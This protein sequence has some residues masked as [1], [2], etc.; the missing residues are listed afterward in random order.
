ME[1]IDGDVRV[2][3]AWSTVL[4]EQHSKIGVC[5]K[6]SRN[7]FDPH[8]QVHKMYLSMFALLHYHGV[9]GSFLLVIPRLMLGSAFPMA[10][11]NSHNVA[12]GPVQMTKRSSINHL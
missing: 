5:S 8:V 6:C 2:G 10:F 9:G 12:T 3:I 11:L 4:P 7:V 1:R